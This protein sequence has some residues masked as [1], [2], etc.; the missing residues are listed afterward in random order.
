MERQEPGHT[1]DWRVGFKMEAGE[2]GTSPRERP[3]SLRDRFFSGDRRF[4]R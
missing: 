3:L 1:A 4:G 2:Q